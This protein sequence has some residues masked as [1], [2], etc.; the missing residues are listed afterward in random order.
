MEWFFTSEGLHHG[1]DFSDGELQAWLKND[2]ATNMAT[3]FLP[4]EFSK[5][6]VSWATLDPHT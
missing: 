4:W 6:Q 5:G 3:F 1:Q 2:M